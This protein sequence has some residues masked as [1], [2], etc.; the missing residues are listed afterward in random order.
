[1][2]NA[3]NSRCQVRG[4]VVHGDDDADLWG[5]HQYYLHDIRELELKPTITVRAAM[6][7]NVLV[8]KDLKLEPYRGAQ[9]DWSRTQQGGNS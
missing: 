6:P 9:R 5:I 7:I 3:P 2:E 4:T 8:V 1:M